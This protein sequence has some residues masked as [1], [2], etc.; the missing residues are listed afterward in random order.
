MLSGCLT[1]LGFTRCNPACEYGPP[2]VVYDDYR[3]GGVVMD[4]YFNPLKGIE[5]RIIDN[6]SEK[7]VKFYTDNEGVFESPILKTSKLG[8]Q[9]LQFTDI[10][11]EDNGGE[12][13]GKTISI[14][15]M[16]ELEDNDENLYYTYVSLKHK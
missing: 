8:E 3:V 14:K 10:D 6:N 13:S 7:D 9:S 2:P 12:F 11:G 5:V 1:I 15:Q 16:D 4:E